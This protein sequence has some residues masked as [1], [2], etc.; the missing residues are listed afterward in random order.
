[1]HKTKFLSLRLPKSLVLVLSFLCSILWV[2]T[3]S[4]Q[5]TDAIV[6]AFIDYTDTARE[7]IYLHLNKS[8]Y[9]KGESI[10]FTAYVMDKKE[11]MPSLL[12]T[13]LY[14]SIEDMNQNPIKQQLLRVNNGVTS[15]VIDIDDKFATGS[16]IVKA[17]TNWSRNFK[18]PNYFATTIKIIDPATDAY[19]DTER[20][21]TAIDAQF[22]P[23]SGHLLANVVNKVG[24]VIKDTKGYGL[25]NASGKV[26]DNDGQLLTSFEVNHLGIGQFLL[27][28][29]VGDAYSIVITHNYKAVSYTHLTLPTT[30]RV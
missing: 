16:Y 22:L 30:S 19:V 26:F 2:H 9:I 12:T 25:S 7:V 24:V 4:A 17:Y 10:G 8:T 5:K 27:K 28:P 20:V 15:N 3:A 29:S 21:E 23:E 1:M 14:V 11:K 13:N 6:D 18:E